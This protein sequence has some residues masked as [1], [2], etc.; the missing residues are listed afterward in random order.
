MLVDANILLYAVDEDSPFHDR[1]RAWLDDAL[2]GPERV[3]IPWQSYW[4]FLRIG[5]SPRI[6]AN[7]LT[8]ARAWAYVDAWYEAPATWIPVPGRGHG[9]ILHDLLVQLD[10]RAGLVS[11]AV[12]AALCLEHG[13]SIVSA[14]SDFARFPQVR[15]VNP[16]AP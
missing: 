2:N 8:P 7:P 12:L 13:L 1:A 3:G 6:F 9:A 16:V 4:A 10:L 5:T 15:W 11:D 14:D